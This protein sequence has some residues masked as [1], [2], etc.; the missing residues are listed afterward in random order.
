MILKKINDF[1][2]KLIKINDS[3]Q[4]VALGFSL[5]V[6]LGIIPGSGPIASL[7]LAFLF[8]LNRASSLLGSLAVNTWFSFLVLVPA[9]KLAGIIFNLN[10]Q[11]LYNQWIVLVSEFKWQIILKFSL[12]KIILPIIVAYGIIALVVAIIVYPIVLSILKRCK[13]R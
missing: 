1:I 3:P 12:Y 5:G 8:K 13:Y 7:F 2:I 10:W 6:A 9:V 11:N 4:K